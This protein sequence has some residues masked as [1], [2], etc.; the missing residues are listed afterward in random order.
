MAQVLWKVGG[1][2]YGT[3]AFEDD[4]A[5]AVSI[6]V[7]GVQ[8]AGTQ[9]AAIASMTDST[10]GTVDGTLADVGAAFSQATLNNNF[11]D[12]NAKIDEVLTALRNHGLIA[13]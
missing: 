11:A 10:G 2:S 12:V 1:G 4:G 7:N 13:T 9:Q 3:A 8:V 5:G 6:K